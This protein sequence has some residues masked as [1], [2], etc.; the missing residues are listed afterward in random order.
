MALPY[1]LPRTGYL[2]HYCR[3]L[4]YILRVTPATINLWLCLLPLA[5]D[6][7]TSNSRWYRRTPHTQIHC[8]LPTSIA[9]R[10]FD[11]S[12]LRAF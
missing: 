5:F 7:P 8:P 10:P 11:A 4:H 6:L 1:R 12:R 9:H 2:V 3:R